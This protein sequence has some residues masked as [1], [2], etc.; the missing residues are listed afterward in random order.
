MVAPINDEAEL[1]RIARKHKAATRKKGGRSYLPCETTDT[2]RLKK[3]RHEAW[4]QVAGLI[5]EAGSDV[6]EIL[7][8]M[9]SR[10]WSAEERMAQVVADL[11]AIR[12][13]EDLIHGREG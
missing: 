4:S 2:L 5:S 7:E 8:A 1:L 12:E 11:Q 13:V 3:A 10:R 9:R 6:A